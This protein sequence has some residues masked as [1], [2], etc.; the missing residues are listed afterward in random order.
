MTFLFYKFV[1]KFS[2]SVNGFAHGSDLFTTGF[3]HG[4]D[5]SSTGFTSATVTSAAAE[6]VI[7]NV[8]TLK[9]QNAW[10]QPGIGSSSGKK[11]QIL[12]NAR[13]MIRCSKSIGTSDT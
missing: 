10:K 6:L 9:K 2:F 4:F 3:A 1:L 13:T 7:Q 11:H 8:L 5:L 12:M